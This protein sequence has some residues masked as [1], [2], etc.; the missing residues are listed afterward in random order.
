MRA[1][2]DKQ[3]LALNSRILSYLREQFPGHVAQFDD[4]RLLEAVAALRV[5]AEAYGFGRQSSVLAF[6]VLC[7]TVSPNFDRHEHIH[8]LL[9]EAHLPADFRIAYLADAISEAEWDD[10][11]KMGGSLLPTKVASQ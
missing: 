4:R 5:R 3:R 11:R 10:A 7:V 2:E 9:S 8:Q 6:A 1:F